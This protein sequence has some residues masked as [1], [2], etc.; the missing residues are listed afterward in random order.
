MHLSS[1]LQIRQLEDGHSDDE[2][3]TVTGRQSWRSRRGATERSGGTTL[4]TATRCGGSRTAVQGKSSDLPISPRVSRSAICDPITREPGTH[5]RDGRLRPRP[6]PTIVEPAQLVLLPLHHRRVSPPVPFLALFPPAPLEISPPTPRP[7]RFR[8]HVRDV[9][10]H[11]PQHRGRSRR[12]RRP[13][14]RLTHRRRRP[15]AGCGARNGPLGVV[16]RR[17]RSHVTRRPD[18]RVR[19]C[20]RL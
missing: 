16:L 20:P 13:R 10:A 8:E 9:G 15:D 6:Q 2:G 12:W 5:P 19:R 14:A 4:G 11:P 18:V 3:G 17:G 7:A 1:W